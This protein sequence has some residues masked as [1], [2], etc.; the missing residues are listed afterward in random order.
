MIFLFIGAIFIYVIGCL[1]VYRYSPKISVVLL[2]LGCLIFIG[3][4]TKKNRIRRY[5]QHPPPPQQ[6]SACSINSTVVSFDRDK[7]KLHRNAGKKL[8]QISLA[9]NNT[10]RDTLIQKEVLVP[11]QNSDGYI[12]QQM[13][14]GSPYVHS[15][16]FSRIQEIEKRF[17][18]KQ[19]QHE[20]SGVKFVITSAYR[21]LQDQ[22][23]LREINGNATKGISSH[24]YGASIDVAELQG[25]QCKE[26][27]PLFE[28]VI[29][30][31]QKEKKLYLCPE[32]ITIHLTV[33]TK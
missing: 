31:M 10:Q 1:V 6:P 12:V 23:R 27:L 18:E 24:S 30:E 9:D 13:E 20:I 26:A 21:T 11:I 5:V 8:S 32:S 7:Y 25:K 4:Y 14:F 28:E 17:L 2:F 29:Q 33:R 19:K 15:N 3:I 22:Q 16:M